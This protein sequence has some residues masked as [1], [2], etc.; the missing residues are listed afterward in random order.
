MLLCVVCNTSELIDSGGMLYVILFF[1]F[2]IFRR[3]Y[4]MFIKR[5][6]NNNLHALQLVLSYSIV[7]EFSDHEF[8]Y[9]FL[10]LFILWQQQRSAL[11]VDDAFACW[12]FNW[13][14]H[15]SGY[16]RFHGKTLLTP[17]TLEGKQFGT[18]RL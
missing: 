15:H 1:F 7:L 10:I 18:R 5:R 2:D 8:D 12:Q 4:S 16:V 17:P 11:D 6:T 3:G 14:L 13:R 9:S